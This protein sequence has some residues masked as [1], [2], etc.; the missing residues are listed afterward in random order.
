MCL[1]V[2]VRIKTRCCTLTE[3]QFRPI[4]ADNYYEQNLFWNELDRS[5]TKKLVTLFT[6]SPYNENA[7]FSKNSTKWNS[8]F[9][10]LPTSNTGQAS[11]YTQHTVLGANCTTSDQN[12]APWSSCAASAFCSETHPSKNSAG[13]EAANGKLE[14]NGQPSYSS[15]VSK[16]DDVAVSDGGISIPQKT[17]SSLFKTSSDYD[18][19]REN[20]NSRVQGST[21]ASHPSDQSNTKLNATDIITCMDKAQGRFPE[22]QGADFVAG[23]YSQECDTWESWEEHPYAL[24]V[25]AESIPHD[26]TSYSD[27]DFGGK[28]DGDE[29]FETIDSDLHIRHLEESYMEWESSC[30][31]QLGQKTCSPE[32]FI[33]WGAEEKYDQ[34]K[35]NN[36]ELTYSSSGTIEMTSEVLEKEAKPS[37]EIK[38]ETR[39]FPVIDIPMEIEC[40]DIQSVVVKV[41]NIISFVC[42]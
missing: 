39:F 24:T 9:Y 8:L 12:N 14:W 38:E 20:G 7:S 11:S 33:D 26:S 22:T 16:K 32:D 31:R 36:C 2:R 23:Q 37:Y 5:Q 10:S 6:S 27:A 19:S 25:A 1:K 18:I 28:R 3:D 41:C 17:W 13:A 42:L 35:P 30:L 21:S 4:I 40:S 34:L 29:C 15:I